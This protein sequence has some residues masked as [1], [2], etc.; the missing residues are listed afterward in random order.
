MALQEYRK[1]RTTSKTPEPFGGKPSGDKLQFV[2]QKHAASH[3]HYDF[4]LEVKGVLKSWAI[5]KGPSMDPAIKYL[6]MLVEDHS[7]DYK[8]FEGIISQGQ[9]GGGTVIIWDQGTYEPP[10]PAETK[11][12][13]EKIMLKEFYG[14]SIKIRMHGKKLK[15]EFPWSRPRAG[16]T[17]R[18]SSSSTVTNT[19]PPTTSPKRINPSFP[20]RPSSKWQE[21]RP[22]KYGTAIS[23]KRKPLP[24]PPMP[25]IS[26][27]PRSAPTYQPFHPLKSSNLRLR[28]PMAR[29]L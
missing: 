24:M 22:P 18:G 6:A 17:M 23:R 19:P 21:A 29:R 25:K 12:D 27:T 4:R 7:Y 2:V 1:K 13:Q 9:Y 11:A 14:G 28:P 20:K 8:D 16:A 26:K 15:G 3:L 10:E 5:P